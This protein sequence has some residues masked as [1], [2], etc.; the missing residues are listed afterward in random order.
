MIVF[1]GLRPSVRTRGS[2]IPRLQRCQSSFTFSTNKLLMQKEQL[3]DEKR[4][5]RRSEAKN[6]ELSAEKDGKKRMAA[7]LRGKQRKTDFSWLPKAPSTDHLKHRDVSTTLLYS[8]Y[9]PFVLSPS[10][11]KQTDSTLYEFAMKLEAL[12]DPLPWI[13]SAT[14][15]E[16]YGEWDNIPADVIKK[17]RPFEPP[18]NDPAAKDKEALKLLQKEIVQKEKNKLINRAKGRKKPILR[19]LQLSKKMGSEN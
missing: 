18:T 14:G 19:L 10:E 2:A 4:K 1:R 9:R 16:F 8:G 12:G 15:T 5:N 3:K 17:L 11:Q 7:E 6:E 13:S